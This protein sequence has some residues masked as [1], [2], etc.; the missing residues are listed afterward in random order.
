M[1]RLSTLS[2]KEQLSA[3]YNCKKLKNQL[4]ERVYENTFF[5]IDEKLNHFNTRAASWSVGICNRDEHF[6]VRDHSEF[7]D[8]VQASI[9]DFSASDRVLRKADQCEKLRG[10]NLFEYHVEQLC[11]MFYK[12]EIKS[13]VD[14]CEDMQYKVYCEDEDD[15]L[16][17][18]ATIMLDGM[19]VFVNDDGEI[20]SVDR[21]GSMA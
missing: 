5:W 21:L 4:N 14:F 7:L 18:E 11:N 10:S 2:A 16:L 12:D 6:S 19:D 9:N 1:R 3:V 8:C 15:F 13:E 17:E 20:F